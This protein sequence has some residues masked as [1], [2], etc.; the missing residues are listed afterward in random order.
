MDEKGGALHQRMDA[1]DGL[2]ARVPLPLQHQQTRF[3]EGLC[4]VDYLPKVSL[5]P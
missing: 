5:Q 2:V 1:E 3:F 4:L